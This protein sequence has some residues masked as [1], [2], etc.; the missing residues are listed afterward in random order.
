MT[1]FNTCYTNDAITISLWLCGNGGYSYY[2]GIFTAQN[3][4]APTDWQWAVF[5]QGNANT[6][7]MYLN[8]TNADV[9]YAITD[10]TW[11]HFCMVGGSGSWKF[12]VNG[13]DITSGTCNAIQQITNMVR[14]GWWD[15]AYGQYHGRLAGL[16]VYNR[17]LTDVEIAALA[18]EFTPS[19]V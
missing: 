16:R 18:A 3:G 4:N 6:I 14:I 2:D 5:N 13:S 11:Y 10:D 15:A 7:D 17:A 9:D 19:A 1:K 12:Y 8:G